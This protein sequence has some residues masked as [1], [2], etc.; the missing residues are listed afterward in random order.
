MTPS[1]ADLP[2]SPRSKTTWPWGQ[3]APT[4]PSKMPDGGLWPRISIII[5]SFNQAEFLEEALRSIL[6]QGYPDL[7]LIVMDGGSTDGSR[8]ILEKYSNWITHW[9]S[10]EDLGQSHAINKGFEISTGQII[11]WMNSD[12]IYYPAAFKKAVEIFMSHPGIS[13]VVG[14]CGQMT[15][16]CS[17][18]NVRPAVDFD[19][20]RIVMGGGIP[21]Q[22]AVFLSNEVV[23]KLGGMREDLYY[24]L[25]WEYWL[26]IGYDFPGKVQT[27]DEILAVERIWLGRKT[28]AKAGEASARERRKVL[29]EFFSRLDLP[30]HWMELKSTAFSET[31][32]R[33][34]RSQLSEDQRNSARRSF[35]KAYQLS[36]S[37]PAFMKLCIYSVG[38][39]IGYSTSNKIAQF[40]PAFLRDLWHRRV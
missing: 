9:E 23:T 1:L 17:L 10:Q 35:R 5:P 31:Y 30:S 28:L 15:E 26:R 34:G 32:W 22:P 13:G 25:D 4:L 16:D 38:S 6:L 19:A 40:A 8:E 29:E 27:I 18:L 21:G 11:A 2:T 3:E 37:F 12:D 36:S 39:L 7:E 33:Q 24:I 14:Q 20:K